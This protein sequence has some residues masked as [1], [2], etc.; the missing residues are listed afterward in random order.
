M[1]H[2]NG[3]NDGIVFLHAVADGPAS[4]SYGLQV[5][6]LAG[7]PAEAIRRA[8]AYL[9]R[10]DRFSAGGGPQADLFAAPGAGMPDAAA[11]AAAEDAAAAATNRV[12]AAQLAALDPD[13]MTPREALAALYEL[14]RA[15]PDP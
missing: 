5:A 12:L 7:V 1:L 11:H 15:Q 13:A 9:A 8:K 3:R 10:I 6:R 2:A 14:K 4:Q